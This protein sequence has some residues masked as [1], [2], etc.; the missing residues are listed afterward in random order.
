MHTRGGT[1]L[2]HVAYSMCRPLRHVK[3]P[4]TQGAGPHFRD[5]RS[6]G[7]RIVT[8]LLNS[9]TAWIGTSTT[10]IFFF[11]YFFGV[12]MSFSSS[13]KS[14]F[15]EE[16]YFVLS[17]QREL[18]C[19]IV[20]SITQTPNVVQCDAV[21]ESQL[22]ETTATHQHEN[23]Y[24][25][26]LDDADSSGYTEEGRF[27]EC[28]TYHRSLL[29]DYLR[30]WGPRP[31]QQ[32]DMTAN[33]SGQTATTSS[34][35]SS[36]EEANREYRKVPAG[37][38]KS[39]WPRNVPTAQEVT[40]LECDLFFCERNPKY[41]RRNDVKACHETKFLIA[42]YYASPENEDRISQREKGFLV[43]KELAE[44]GYADAMCFYGTFLALLLH[45]NQNG[46]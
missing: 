28:V 30:R 16:E 37:N 22:P 11:S 17:I 41:R 43:V 12:E 20:R 29:H 25:V 6:R 34:E 21:I 27:Y 35:T 9:R 19:R 18:Y 13:L 42:A 1:L 5:V 3:R 39:R 24:N 32:D 8:F 45:I 23:L 10:T 26:D 7:C 4:F 2:S 38:G 15:K 40:A 44:Q 33:D 36:D 14:S 46:D 31:C